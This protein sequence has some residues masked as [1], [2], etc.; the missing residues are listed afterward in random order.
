VADAL[1]PLDVRVTSTRLHPHNI[2]R[3]LRQAGHTP[4]PATFAR[5]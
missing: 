3:L 5:H 4:D 1:A 2:R